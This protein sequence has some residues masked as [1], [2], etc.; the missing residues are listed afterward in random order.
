MIP[1]PSQ[2]VDTGAATLERRGDI[3]EVRF[4]PDVKLDVAGMAEVVRTKHEMCASR[5]ADILI[6]LPA[7][8]DFEL[9]V[10]AVNHREV[11]GGCGMSR[12][13]A[14]VASSPFNER[15][16]TIYFRYHPRE[17]ETAVFVEEKDALAWLTERLP[18]PSLS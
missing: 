15:I 9:N 11:N 14:L 10:L 7:D 18:Q 4:K 16:A 17:E 13:L 12:R 2:V 3:V 1:S 8:L 6:V 5:A